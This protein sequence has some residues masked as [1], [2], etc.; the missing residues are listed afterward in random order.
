MRRPKPH[1]QRGVRLAIAVFIACV[2]GYGVVL[3]RGISK[4]LLFVAALRQNALVCT[5]R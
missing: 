2:I 4:H 1:V 3:P 5:L